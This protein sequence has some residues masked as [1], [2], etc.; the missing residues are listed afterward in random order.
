MLTI[1]TTEWSL[2]VRVSF[3]IKLKA[4]GSDA[5]G[6]PSQQCRSGIFIANFEH[7]WL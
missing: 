3:L 4:W 7:C 1:K 6:T 5:N 2:C